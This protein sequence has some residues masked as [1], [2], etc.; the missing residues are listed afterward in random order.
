MTDR[1]LARRFEDACRSATTLAEL[2]CEWLIFMPEIDGLT[3]EQREPLRN[4]FA[5]HRD[6]ILG[7][8]VP[9]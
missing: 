8:K 5:A 9:A 4:V 3:D 2:H 6:R 1:P 7:K